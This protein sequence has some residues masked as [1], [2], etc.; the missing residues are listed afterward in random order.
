M[1]LAGLFV[2][3]MLGALAAP[4]DFSD[5]VAKHRG[6]S[7]TL[8]PDRAPIVLRAIAA[9]LNTR[10]PTGPRYGV[11]KK[12]T[13]NNCGGLA[14]DIVC[15]ADGQHF[16]VFVD[17]PSGETN[18]PGPSRPTWQDKGL[19]DPARCEIVGAA[20]IPTPTPTPCPT[21]PPDLSAELAA[22]RDEAAR[23]RS[24]A[25][26]LNDEVRARTTERDDARRER[27]ECRATEPRCELTGPGWA[28]SLFKIGCRVV[29]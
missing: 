18:T 24:V 15:R 28:R 17:G 29:R 2:A 12:P 22:A 25:D 5:V 8:A 11:L 3:V 19:I 7:A 21:C 6:D 16:D 4:Q 20:P 13:G 10:V 9:E 26:A 23:L 14:C 1:R 27:D